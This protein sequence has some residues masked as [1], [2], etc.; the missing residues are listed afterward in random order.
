MRHADGGRGRGRTH[1]DRHR[2]AQDVARE[3]HDLPRQRG[4]EEERLPPLRH[5]RHHAPDVRQE[6]DV[7]HAV[8]LVDDEHLEPAQRRVAVPEVV[9][10]AAGRGDD[11]V[12]AAA[13]RLLLHAHADA[14]VDR[15]N[16][17]RSPARQRG[18]VRGDLAGQLARRRQDQRA[19]GAALPAVQAMEDRQEEGRGLAAAGHGAAEHVTPFQ[20][21]R[22]RS[23]LDRR[24]RHESE[25][26][27]GVEKVRVQRQVRKRQEESASNRQ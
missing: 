4:R 9:E 2:V 8:R 22:D 11:D 1:L 18:Q 12:H 27:N 13:Q 10:Q 26:G 7:E 14:A 3:R 15:G 16:A 20:D 25:V 21:G 19:R 6:P 23:L 17:Q 24:R 5:V